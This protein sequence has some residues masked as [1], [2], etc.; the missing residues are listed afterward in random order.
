[1]LFLFKDF[2]K[3]K[4]YYKHKYPDFDFYYLRCVNLNLISSLKE[5]KD[6]SKAEDLISL[7]LNSLLYNIFDSYYT[8]RG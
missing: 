1:M 5:N 3:D 7:H 6:K 2:E 4:S 8:E